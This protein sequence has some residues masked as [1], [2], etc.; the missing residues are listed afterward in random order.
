[1]VIVICLKG[2]QISESSNQWN[3][4]LSYWMMRNIFVDGRNRFLG[5]CHVTSITFPDFCGL[6]DYSYKVRIK[7]S[8]MIRSFVS[9][10]VQSFQIISHTFDHALIIWNWAK[11]C[12]THY[13]TWYGL[14]VKRMK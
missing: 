1:M 3:P 11:V 4:D 7:G 14:L 10:S 6:H 9:S 8:R 5:K 2:R 13:R 12:P